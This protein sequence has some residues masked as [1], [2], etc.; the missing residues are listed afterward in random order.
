M[1]FKSI[2]TKIVVIAGLCLISAVVLL[3]GYGLYSSKSTQDAVSKEVSSLLTELNMERL[4][5]LAGEQ[6]GTIQSE[7]AL[8]LDAARTMA[9]TFEV[10]KFKPKDGKGALDIGRDQLNAILLNVLKRNT[11]FNGTYSCWEPNAIDGADE[12][13]RVNKDGNNPTTGRFTPL[14]DA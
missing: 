7:L 3:V 5:N 10:S 12:N 1:I 2:Q 14:L 8:A 6:S 13:F 11:S 4:Q 9:N